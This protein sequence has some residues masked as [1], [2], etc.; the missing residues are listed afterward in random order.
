MEMHSIYSSAR[1]LQQ[2]YNF[3]AP[4]SCKSILIP[5][6]FTRVGDLNDS[7]YIY[8]VA[9]KFELYSKFGEGWLDQIKIGDVLQSVDGVFIENLDLELKELLYTS[10]RDSVIARWIEKLTWR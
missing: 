4:F 3:P 7:S 8:A 10:N 6:E 2:Q 9:H 5:L 1:D